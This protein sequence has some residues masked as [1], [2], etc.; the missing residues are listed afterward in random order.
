MGLVFVGATINQSHA[1]MHSRK[2]NV[3]LLTLSTVVP[4]KTKLDDQWLLD[5]GPAAF[6]I[7]Y[8]WCNQICWHLPVF[9]WMKEKNVVTI[10]YHIMSLS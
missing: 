1:Q 6:L 7:C 3:A 10:F 9:L 2:K 5:D 4:S 8:W